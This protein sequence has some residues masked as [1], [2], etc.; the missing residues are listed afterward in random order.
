[1]SMLVILENKH[2]KQTRKGNGWGCSLKFKWKSAL[3][4]ETTIL[5]GRGQE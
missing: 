3:T 5:N 1:M 2:E 4:N